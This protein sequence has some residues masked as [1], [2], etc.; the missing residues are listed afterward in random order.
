MK[1]TPQVPRRQMHQE[2]DKREGKGR[3]KERERKRE[4]GRKKKTANPLNQSL[5][6]ISI[7]TALPLHPPQGSGKGCRVPSPPPANIWVLP[8]VLGPAH[9]ASV[10]RQ[11][12]KYHPCL[13]LPQKSKGNQCLFP[14]PS[15]P[16]SSW[17]PIPNQDPSH[18]II[19][20]SCEF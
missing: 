9:H 19:L 20:Q 10:R 2:R 5:D 13:S 6:S 18:S 17:W 14:P 11:I 7:S 16:P 15:V 12:S 8:A 4:R 1:R 3:K